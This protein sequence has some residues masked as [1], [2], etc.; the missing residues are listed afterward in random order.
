MGYVLRKYFELSSY[1]ISKLTLPAY[2]LVCLLK[3]MYFTLYKYGTVWFEM[4][5]L[6]VSISK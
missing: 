5:T 2:I 4:S 6:A 3:N 1:Q